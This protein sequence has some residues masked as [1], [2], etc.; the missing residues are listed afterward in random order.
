MS[1][2]FVAEVKMFAGNFAPRGYATCNGQLLPISQNTAL[3]SLIGTYYGGNGSSNFQLPNFAG[4]SPMSQGQGLGLSNYD[5]GENGGQE[6]HALLQAE[7]PQHNHSWVAGEETVAGSGS[8]LPTGN[9][10]GEASPSKIYAPSVTGSL[11]QM[12]PSTI[13]AAGG[14]QPHNN[15][16]PYLCVTFL[17]ALTG[18]YPQRN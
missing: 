18:I 12:S 4:L 7:M 2:P 9:Y 6:T 10:L 15:Q 16:Q 3:F 11:V 17:I 8:N 13:V 14:N 1:N 5:V